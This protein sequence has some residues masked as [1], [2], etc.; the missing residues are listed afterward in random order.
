MKKTGKYSTSRP[1]WILLNLISKEWTMPL[2][3]IQ[4][5]SPISSSIMSLPTNYTL[6]RWSPYLKKRQKH[7][8]NIN[9]KSITFM[10]KSTKFQHNYQQ[11]HKLSSGHKENSLNS[12]FYR[13]SWTESLL[14]S[15]IGKMSSPKIDMRSQCTSKKM[16][17]SKEKCQI[18]RNNFKDKDW[19]CYKKTIKYPV[20]GFN[21]PH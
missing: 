15:L 14:H 3:N 2:T 12:N 9:N 16:K 20:S 4:G 5:K 6:N 19:K 17:E 13:M 1:D 18:W 10:I 21:Y 11:E 7:W 8:K